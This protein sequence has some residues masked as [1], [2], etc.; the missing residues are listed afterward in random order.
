MNLWYTRF[1]LHNNL[2]LEDLIYMFTSIEG[3]YIHQR[4][5][6]LVLHRIKNASIQGE[7]F[8]PFPFL[9]FLNKFIL[10]KRE[11]VRAALNLSIKLFSKL[12]QYLFFP[13]LTFESSNLDVWLILGTSCLST[14]PRE[15][16]ICYWAL[17]RIFKGR[18]NKTS[19]Y[20]VSF[21][22][23]K[24]FVCSRLCSDCT[25]FLVVTSLEKIL[26]LQ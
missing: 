5:Y 15:T 22:L 8:Y 26:G 2:S 19:E 14:E 3:S 4:I 13:V 25:H 24:L 9:I 11:N 18:C 7:C 6:P 10:I 1:I 12:P 23:L 21:Q 16:L 17:R 20:R